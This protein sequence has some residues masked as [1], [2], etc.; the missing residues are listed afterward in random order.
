MRG[1]FPHADRVLAARNPD[2]RR[3]DTI[4]ATS[5]I[6]PTI[7]E[8]AGIDRIQSWHDRPVPGPPGKSLVPVLVG[9]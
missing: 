9:R 6:W 2:A 8:A 5:L 7:L 1:G 4:L 3:G